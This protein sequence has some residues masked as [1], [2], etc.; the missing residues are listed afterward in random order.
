MGVSLLRINDRADFTAF[1]ANKRGRMRKSS[2]KSVF[3]G[4]WAKKKPGKQVV[5]G[6]S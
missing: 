5:S 2:E 6:L 3:F 4:A 1:S